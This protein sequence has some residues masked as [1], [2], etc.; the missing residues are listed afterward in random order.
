L[1]RI[2]QSEW[3]TEIEKGIKRK[4][5]KRK[6]TEKHKF[7]VNQHKWRKGDCEIEN[8]IEKYKE[9]KGIE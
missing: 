5:H 2:D 9:G 3:H 4:T 1:F 6:R 8:R 7:I